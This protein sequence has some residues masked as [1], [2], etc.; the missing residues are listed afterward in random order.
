MSTGNE[1]RGHEADT[2]SL[3]DLVVSVLLAIRSSFLTFVAALG[4]AMLLLGAFG[5]MI[6]VV[7]GVMK[8]VVAGMFGIWGVSAIVYAVIGF[9]FL[10]LIGY[11]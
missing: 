2:N 5:P 6:P 7:N 3:Y 9:G 1:E 10:R 8:G 11:R 4:V